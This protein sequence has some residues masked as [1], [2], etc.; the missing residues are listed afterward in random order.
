MHIPLQNLF[1]EETSLSSK[2][3][4]FWRKEKSLQVWGKLCLPGSLKISAQ[5]STQVLKINQ[6]FKTFLNF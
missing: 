6:T 4:Q 1:W 2:T 3:C 5:S